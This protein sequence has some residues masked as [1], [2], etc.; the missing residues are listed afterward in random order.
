MVNGVV[1]CEDPGVSGGDRVI[2]LIFCNTI[3]G[4]NGIKP[5]F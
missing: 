5:G 3:S 2:S 4:L 1:I